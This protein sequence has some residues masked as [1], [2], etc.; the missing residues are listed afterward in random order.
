MTDPNTSWHLAEFNVARL[1]V[2]LDHDQNAEFVAVLGAVNLIAEVSPGFVWRLE[3]DDG[4]SASYVVAYDDPLLILNL[5]VWQDVD[6]LRHYVYRS[7]HGAYFRRRSQWFEAPGDEANLVCW[8]LPA[9]TWPTVDEA[10]SR[11]E[12]M[13]RTGPGPDGFT[14]AE[15]WPAPA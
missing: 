11:L 6:S 13:R 14:L 10:V 2:P 4:R 5:S 3:A 12:S 1:H 15:S 9:G 8:W 7:G